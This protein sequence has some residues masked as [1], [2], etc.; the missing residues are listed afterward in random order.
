MVKKMLS[1][2][3]R[4]SLLL[5]TV[6]MNRYTATLNHPVKLKILMYCTQFQ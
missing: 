2:D 1:F 3:V 5:T 4:I 6:H